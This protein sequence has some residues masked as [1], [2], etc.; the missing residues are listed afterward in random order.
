M[1]NFFRLDEEGN[2]QIEQLSER[3]QR[4]VLGAV[5]YNALI[6]PGRTLTYKIYMGEKWQYPRLTDTSTLNGVLTEQ[7]GLNPIAVFHA[8]ST[9]EPQSRFSPHYFAG[10]EQLIDRNIRFILLTPD[11]AT[12]DDVEQNYPIGKATKLYREVES[13]AP[14]FFD[15]LREA[16][17]IRREQISR[18]AIKPFSPNTTG[19]INGR[20]HT[21]HP[22]V[23]IA[24]GK[25]DLNAPRAVIIAMHWL[26][27]GGAERWALET[28]SLVKEAGF[29]PIVITDSDGHQPWI[30]RSELKGTVLL[31]LTMPLQE[32]VGDAPLL[33]AL[34]EQFNIAGILI[35]HCQWMYDNAWWVKKFFPQTHIVDS[36]HIVEYIF[37][38]GY[39]S[40]SVARDEWI[41]LHHV[42]SPQLEH[43]LK[44]IHHIDP[45]KVIDAPLVGLTAD[46]AGLT[47]KTR[48]TSQPLVVS[49]VGR[50]VRQK[51]P[52]T[53][54]LAARAINKAFP[55]KVKF[56]MHGNGDMDAFV[57]RLIERYQ[58]EDVIERRSM[59]IPVGTTYAET[60]V[61]LV[62]SMNE[63]ITLTTIEALSAGI[64]VVSANIGSQ[65]T[66]IP[67]QGLCRRLSASFVK[68]AK[69]ILGH[70]LEHEENREKLW[71][72]EAKR[73]QEFSELE[74]AN[75][76][77]RNMLTEWSR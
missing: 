14:A 1:H 53:F 37:H 35:H 75:D 42:I 18:T 32:R 28:I 26:Q 23:E 9:V 47:F 10:N 77:F 61:L 8:T 38:G 34:F 33:R 66:L 49:F 60:D 69:S 76:Y 15:A 4:L 54:I 74:S 17:R 48:D 20:S 50:N 62:S 41:D 40:E 52:E 67:P 51:R 70:I 12:D 6:Q 2:Q 19:K 39:P 36:L 21:H 7:A 59:S 29:I 56:I 25:A 43:W 22:W 72:S 65:D 63:G 45:H 57:D 71:R 13:T 3:M 44:D 46:S 64:P 31:P 30:T 5:N 73:L 55:G 16:K 11:E 68:D 58:L 24:P 27:S